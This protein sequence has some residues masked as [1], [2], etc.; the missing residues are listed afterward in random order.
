M[1]RVIVE[2][3]YAGAVET[4]LEYVRACMADCIKRGESPFASHALYTQPGVLD[5]NVQAERKLGIEAGLAWGSVADATVVYTDLGISGGM[6][7]G[8]ERAERE[9]RPVEKRA[10]GGVWER[11]FV[12]NVFHDAT[13][14]EVGA[15][16]AELDRKNPI[17]TFSIGVK[18]AMHLAQ[19]LYAEG[20]EIL[21]RF[22]RSK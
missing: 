7:I 8:I 17:V 22:K 18:S 2:S 12:Q 15:Q 4:N 19:F 21:V 20:V 10:L 3:P 11:S 6:Q 1:R 16:E 14:V 9:G 5:D 13:L